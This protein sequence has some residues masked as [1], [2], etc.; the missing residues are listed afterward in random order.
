M[1][2]QPMMNAVRI[3]EFGGPEVLKYEEA[4]RPEPGAGE[5]LLEV[6][7]VGVNPVDWKIREGEMEDQMKHTLPLIPG[8]DAAGIV[9][10]VGPGV[11][12]FAPGDEVF[13]A[14]DMARDGSY[15][16]YAVVKTQTVAAKPASVDFVTAAALPVAGVTAWQCLF[17]TAHLQAGQTVLIH[18]ASGGVGTLAVQLAHW[19]GARVVGTASAQNKEFLQKLGADEVIDYHATRF[20]DVVSGVDVVLDTQG[21]DTQERSWGVLK[22]GG[23]LVTTVPPPPSDAAKAHGVRGEFLFAHP[24][25]AVLA[26]LAALVASGDLTPIIATTLPLAEARRAQEL[27]ATGHTRGKIVLTV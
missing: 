27:S 7:A 1:S 3:H 18:G 26:Q 10:A 13:A 22:P 8:I 9:A 4:P 11:T 21:G 5:I 15:A 16:E 19:K 17:E 2:T 12:E 14:L 20:E 25:T 24:D 6:K 23:S